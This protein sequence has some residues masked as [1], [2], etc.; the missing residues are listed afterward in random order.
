LPFEERV[1]EHVAEGADGI[2]EDVVEHGS[3]G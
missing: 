2:G 1:L 3:G